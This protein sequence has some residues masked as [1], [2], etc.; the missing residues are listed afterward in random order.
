MVDVSV[1]FGLNMDNKRFASTLAASI[2]RDQASVPSR[3]STF[4][5][6]NT[7]DNF[8]IKSGWAS[9]LKKDGSRA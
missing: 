2:E 8:A 5:R 1:S 6:S 3:H 7:V 9:R 4:R